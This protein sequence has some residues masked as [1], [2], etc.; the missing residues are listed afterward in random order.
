MHHTP[1]A[2]RHTPNAPRTG[3]SHDS[4]NSVGDLTL[5]YTLLDKVLADEAA[6]LGR[7]DE[8]VEVPDT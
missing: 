1:H 6:L 7:V 5:P 4:K 8:E 3:S 2:T